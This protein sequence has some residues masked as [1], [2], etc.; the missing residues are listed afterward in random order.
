MATGRY[1]IGCM[2]NP[3][4]TTLGIDLGTQSVKVVFYDFAAREIIAS[5]SA[6]LDLNQDADGKAEQLADW[7]VT[8]L[9]DALTKIPD[10]IKASVV[11]ASVSGQQHGFVALDEAGDVI[12][13]VKLWCDTSTL[14]ECDQ[15]N[16]AMG[17]EKACLAATGNKILAGFTASKVRY[18]KNTHPAIYARMRHILLPHDYLNYWLSGK[19]K[20]EFGDASGTG[21]FDV[22]QRQW[23][24][25]V[26]MAIDGDRDLRECLPELISDNSIIGHITASVAELT[27]LPAGT[28]LAPGGGDNMMGAIGTGNLSSGRATISLGTS[29]T[30]YSYADRPIIDPKGNISAFCSSNGGWLPLLCT[31]NCT[32]SSEIIRKLLNLEIDDFDQA[33]LRSEVGAGGI[34]TVPFFNGERTPNLPNAKACV[35]GLDANNTSPDNL[36]RS[37]VEGASFALRFGLDELTKLGMQIN[38]VVLTGGGANSI[39]WRQIIADVMNVNVLMLRNNE[40]AAFGAALQAY[41]AIK[42]KACDDELLADH[43]EFDDSLSCSPNAADVTAY[44]SVYQEYLRCLKLVVENY[45]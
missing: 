32:V 44:E 12:A 35:F 13:P 7:W 31:M 10:D 17:G 40:G 39:V 6:P 15:I 24:D 38:E 42:G 9:H 26:L 34:S 36:L 4:Q 45:S 16:D 19:L 33:L 43:Y 25:E 3:I 28:P 8:A 27:G 2:T 21:F 41:S 14:A 5:A 20:M 30:V 29:G 22:R 37:A 23:S 1:T 18:L 11:G